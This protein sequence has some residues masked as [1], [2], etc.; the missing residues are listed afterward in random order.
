MVLA[1]VFYGVGQT[2]TRST[3]TIASRISNALTALPFRTRSRSK[4]NLHPL[5]SSAPP[6]PSR[7]LSSHFPPYLTS[8][9]PF[10]P[11]LSPDTDTYSPTSPTEPAWA[12]STRSVPVWGASRTAT[13]WAASKEWVQPDCVPSPGYTFGSPAPKPVHRAPT[14]AIPDTPSEDTTAK[15]VP[16]DTT[17]TTES[18]PTARKHNPAHRG[19]FAEFAESETRAEALAIGRVLTPECD[20]FAKGA[21]SL[22]LPGEGASMLQRRGEAAVQRRAATPR[23]VAGRARRVAYD[24]ALLSSY[25]GTELSMYDGTASAC[26]GGVPVYDASLYDYGRTTP[27]LNARDTPSP[28]VRGASDSPACEMPS[29]CEVYPAGDTR[30]LSPAFRLVPPANPPPMRPLPSIP[31]GAGHG[32]IET[33]PETGIS[34]IPLRLRSDTPAHAHVISPSSVRK[35][36]VRASMPDVPGMR[37]RSPNSDSPRRCSSPRSPSAY[38]PHSPRLAYSPSA[39]SSQSPRIMHSRMS[40]PASPSTSSPS[41]SAFRQRFRHQERE[42]KRQASPFPLGGTWSSPMAHQV[43][44]S[45]AKHVVGGDMSPE[46]SGIHI[47]R[48]DDFRPHRPSSD[49][50]LGTD[51][52]EDGPPLDDSFVLG[53]GLGFKPGFGTPRS[54]RLQQRRSLGSP[55]S[56]GLGSVLGSPDSRYAMGSPESESGRPLFLAASQ[57]GS[58]DWPLPPRWRGEKDIS[59]QV[60]RLGFCTVHSRTADVGM[61]E[62]VIVERKDENGD[63]QPVL[64]KSASMT[65]P[66]PPWS[67]ESSYSAG[68]GSGGAGEDTMVQLMQDEQTDEDD[69]ATAQTCSSTSQTFYSARSSITS[70]EV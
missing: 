7:P 46:S 35:S 28:Y 24:G 53:H 10:P 56:S 13:G 17:P 69:G 30:P 2:S 25:S 68:S 59:K 33:Q 63:K 18:A 16:D 50:C 65:L 36:V 62:N 11:A 20:P 3:S 54:A 29:S 45:S 14:R 39:S 58:Y 41:P 40:L 48:L 43:E 52:D 31:G 12:M 57:H 26:D 15:D 61:Q 70:G 42:R 34:G 66:S 37:A 64:S 19:S 49:Q 32:I 8:P 47:D 23:A 4:L 44:V 6:V 51:R 9:S 67:A 1:F 22:A 38:F 21:I 55:M 5:S 27:A 60:R